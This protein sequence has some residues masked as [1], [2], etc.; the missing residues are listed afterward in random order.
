MITLREILWTVVVGVAISPL[1]LL[2]IVTVHELR[3]RA[4]HGPS[5]NVLAQLFCPAFSR[6][7]HDLHSADYDVCKDPL[8]RFAWWLERV[9][10]YQEKFT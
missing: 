2:M 5:L 8:C 9:T 1:V 4:R 3:Q 10:R 7:C 6:H